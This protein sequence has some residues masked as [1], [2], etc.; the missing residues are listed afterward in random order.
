MTGGNQK[1]DDQFLPA[2]E[3][4]ALF[5]ITPAMIYTW[6]KNRN[7]PFRKS[8]G[9]MFRFSVNHVK[10]LY[11]QRFTQ[12]LMERR[13]VERFPLNFKVVMV[14]ST[15]SDRHIEAETLDISSG[16]LKAKLLGQTAETIIQ[17]EKT[18]LIQVVGF[19]GPLFRDPL[20]ASLRRYERTRDGGILVGVEFDQVKEFM[21]VD[22]EV[23][24]QEV[25]G[26]ISVDFK[27]SLSA[28]EV[29]EL[30]GVSTA[31]V[32]SWVQYGLMSYQKPPGGLFRFPREHVEKLLRDRHFEI[33]S[34]DRRKEERFQFRQTVELIV[35][36]EDVHSYEAMTTDVSPGGVRLLLKTPDFLKHRMR[37]GDFFNV[38]INGLKPPLF[39]DQLSGTIRHFEMVDE[40]QMAVGVELHKGRVGRM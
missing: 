30:F 6:G 13:R 17:A 10:E 9:G 25:K 28:H 35:P 38:V 37:Q 18:G 23:L 34:M 31:D 33:T 1:P 11:D 15:L 29:A 21:P 14:V 22:L 32:F 16:G 27:D 4:A 12:G 7:L 26:F 8:P 5:G 2:E 19:K 40:H 3:L 39:Q 20:N 36:D 24:C